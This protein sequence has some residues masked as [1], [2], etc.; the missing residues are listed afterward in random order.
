MSNHVPIKHHL[1]EVLFFIFNSKKSAEVLLKVIDY[2]RK[3][4]VIIPHRLKRVS[5]GIDTLN[6]VVFIRWTK[7]VQAK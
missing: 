7:N 6:V 3:L 5:T 4:T 2:F 1:R